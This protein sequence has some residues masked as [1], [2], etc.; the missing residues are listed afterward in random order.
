MVNQQERS[1]TVNPW[2]SVAT[3]RRKTVELGST[4]TRADEA[5]VPSVVRGSIKDVSIRDLLTG[6]KLFKLLKSKGKFYL[7][8][9]F[10]WK[11]KGRNFTQWNCFI[12]IS[13]K[14]F[15]S[16]KIDHNEVVFSFP[17]M[18]DLKKGVIALI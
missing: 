2:N 3:E 18:N 9:L 10:P 13:V 8:E 1:W 6:N 4:N 12:Q 5:N 14:N 7:T 11:S 16:E 15:L 17:H